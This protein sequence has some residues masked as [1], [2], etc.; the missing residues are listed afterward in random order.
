MSDEGHLKVAG[1]VKKQENILSSSTNSLDDLN[2]PVYCAVSL[3]CGWL[4][5]REGG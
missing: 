2:I 4:G 1:Y 5:G 3:V